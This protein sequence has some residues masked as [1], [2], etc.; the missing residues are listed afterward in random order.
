MSR[1]RYTTEQIINFIW[2]AEVIVSQGKSL[3]QVCRSLGISEQSY[4]RWRKE[5]GGLRLDQAKRLRETL[6]YPGR[7]AREK[8]ALA[9]GDHGAAAG[10]RPRGGGWIVW[11]AW[12]KQRP[13]REP[14]G[15]PTSHF[16]PA[17][18]GRV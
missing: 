6:S 17:T 9:A 7:Q 5:Y 15:P 4:Y 1:K 13:P 14:P 16:A 2:E 11:P 3:G 10:A 18:L 12:R 8:V